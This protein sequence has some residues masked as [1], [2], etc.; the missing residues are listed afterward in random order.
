MI[1]GT[2]HTFLVIPELDNL[3][4]CKNFIPWELIEIKTWL[5]FILT[6]IYDFYLVFHGNYSLK[7]CRKK[8]ISKIAKLNGQANKKML[9][10]G[11]CWTFNKDFK[12]MAEWLVSSQFLKVMV[13]CSFQCNDFIFAMSASFEFCFPLLLYLCKCLL[14]S[15]LLQ[16]THLNL[17]KLDVLIP[18]N[19]VFSCLQ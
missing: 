8:G 16:L 2:Y 6:R 11:T 18:C 5:T 17:L 4:T 13:A 1:A 10:R 19:A 12:F 9:P 7:C 3:Q 14:K 15:C